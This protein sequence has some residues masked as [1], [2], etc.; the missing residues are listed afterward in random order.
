L[1]SKATSRGRLPS[2]L[3]LA[4]PLAPRRRPSLPPLA[5]AAPTCAGLGCRDHEPRPL[6]S[7]LKLVRRERED[8]PLI[9][10]VLAIFAVLLIAAKM[11]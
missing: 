1:L 2:P 5:A 8:V 7:P 3:P 11:R 6:L 4:P 9:A 10:S